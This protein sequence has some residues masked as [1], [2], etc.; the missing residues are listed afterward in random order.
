MANFLHLA[1]RDENPTVR[2]N[3]FGFLRKLPGPRHQSILPV[4][5]L[6]SVSPLKDGGQAPAYALPSKGWM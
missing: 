4:V 5:W 6:P 2:K 3:R 1:V